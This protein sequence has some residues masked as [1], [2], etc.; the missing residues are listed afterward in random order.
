MRIEDIIDYVL[1][2]YDG[3][4]VD[5]NWGERG[6]FYNPHRTLPK[7]VYLLTFKERDGAN[8]SASNVNRE[9]V[10]RLNLGISKETFREMFGS[11]PSRP[12]AGQHI[13][14]PWD[15]QAL[16]VITPHPV[17]GW[18]AWTAVLSP[19]VKTFEALKPLIGEGYELAVQR[20]R[21]RKK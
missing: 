1:S 20:F 4:V 16:D 17:Y 19:S 9:G 6:L 2:T 7:G 11:M 12:P 3:L 18:M 21:R 5:R 15:F 8:D 14:G 13:A 10:F